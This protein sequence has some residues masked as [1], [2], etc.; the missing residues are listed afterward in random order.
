MQRIRRQA[1]RLT[2]ALALLLMLGCKDQII[3]EQGEPMAVANDKGQQEDTPQDRVEGVI[4]EIVFQNI[5]KARGYWTYNVEL[6]VRHTALLNETSPHPWDH[7]EVVTVRMAKVS[8][9]KLSDDER[10]AISPTGPASRL[11]L[12]SYAGYR[13]GEEVSLDVHFTSP[14]L[15]HLKRR[16]ESP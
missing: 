1:L 14:G 7:P 6:W 15:A 16:S 5:N 13:V 3:K 12:K 9:S 10:A 2:L 11:S 4:E 8:W